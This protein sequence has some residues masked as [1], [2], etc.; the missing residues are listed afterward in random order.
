MKITLITGHDYDSPRRTG[1]HFWADIM[2][3]RGQEVCFLTVGQSSITILNKGRLHKPPYNTWMKRNGSINKF[4]WFPLLHPANMRNKLL[5][6]CTSWLFLNLYPLLMPKD[7]T[8]E[9]AGTTIFIVEVGAGLMLVSRLKK[10][11]PKARF[12]YTVSDRLSTINAHPVAMKAEQDV[13]PHFSK[14][15]VPATI[16]LQDYKSFPAVYIPQGID[17]QVF[18]QQRPNPYKQPRNAISV[19]DMLFD[20]K[21][22]ETMADRFPDWTFHV[23]GRKAVIENLKPNVVVYGE[24]PFHEIT[25]YIQHADI[26][27]APY[28][29]EESAAYLAQS[30]LKMFQYTYC[31][32]PIVA[33]MFAAEG[34]AHAIGYAPDDPDSIARAFK[35]AIDFD[36]AGINT[37]DVLDW[38]QV[39]DRMIAD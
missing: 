3:E 39:I 34:R 7:L 23:F 27:L 38:N 29:F 33:P 25:A 35:Q 32:L 1:F 8:R 6:K 22:I 17:K 13:L 10:T 19:G 26:A 18:D 4:V 15:R 2:S 20:P 21:A 31:R 9:L 30:S 11:F 14:I 16:M 12:I 24:K 28:R 37:A 36:R 5:N